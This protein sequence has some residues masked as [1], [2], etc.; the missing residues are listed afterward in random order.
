MRL[1]I[2]ELD[3]EPSSNQAH[4]HQAIK[5]MGLPTTPSEARSA[6]HRFARDVLKI[7]IVGPDQPHLSVVDV[8]G[9]FHN[10]TEEQTAQDLQTIRD[11]IESYVQD[12]RTIIMAVLDSRNN[13]AAQEVFR[14]AKLAD[15]DGSRTIGVMT[16]LDA[17]QA[18]DEPA[19][20]QIA[21]N[22]VEKL[23]LG[24]YCVRNRTTK[25]IREGFT[26]AQRDQKEA[27]FFNSHMWKS[28][29]KKNV[30][31]TS[32]RISLSKLLS[33]HISREFPIIQEEIRCKYN[34]CLK[35]LEK[36]GPPRQTPQEQTQFLMQ[37]A[38]SF[39]REVDNA[40]EGRY[41]EE[42]MHVSKLRMHIANC[43]SDFDTRMHKKGHTERFGDPK[44]DELKGE[45]LFQSGIYKGIRDQWVCSRGPELP[46]TSNP[47]NLL[48]SSYNIGLVSPLVLQQLMSVQTENWKPIAS[49]FVAGVCTH[50]VKFNVHLREKLCDDAKVRAKIRE[51]LKPLADQCRERAVTQ[52]ETIL[53]DERTGHLLTTNHHLADNIQAARAERFKQRL[54]NL[55]FVDGQV[56][57][58]PINFSQI[59]SSMHLSNENST[60][61]DI[62]D[63]LRAYYSV[64]LNRFVDNVV[65]QVVERTLL[66]PEGSL[67]IFT[68]EFVIGLSD[69]AREKIA[70]EEEE[71][72]DRRVK[73]QAQVARPETAS[74]I[75][76]S[77]AP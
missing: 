41:T 76:A 16:K 3:I 58:A 62:H 69:E 68:P 19:V 72:V 44:N 5:H 4:L 25:E 40:L 22:R 23:K 32:L 57:R 77:T 75:C 53:K 30:G 10:P 29:S 71:V 11:L 21:L 43:T 17:L 55:G 14:I 67:R 15:P 49:K 52:L 38:T 1:G 74:E 31:I 27:E 26:M 20:L 9:L 70:G 64:A 34:G 63:T 59:T 8:P 42:G 37:M 7:E 66:G 35:E 12:R 45:K 51:H 56:Y 60:I 47:T 65:V 46:D 50:L 18:G 48:R 61:L 36:L 6:A 39:Q 13:L 24:W 54:C 73:L 2:T 28:L 33:A